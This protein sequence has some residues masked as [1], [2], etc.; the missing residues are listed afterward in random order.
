MAQPWI[1]LLTGERADRAQSLVR[2]IAETLWATEPDLPDLANGAAGVAL[3]LAYFATI[4]QSRDWRGRAAAL[5]FRAFDT[6]RRSER[7]ESFLKGAAGIA[8]AHRHVQRNF[9]VSGPD[10]SV[11]TIDGL[12]HEQLSQTPWKGV[13]E[14]AHGL[15]GYGVYA[16]ECAD[17]PAG[18]AL[19][20]RVVER[21]EATALPSRHGLTWWTAPQ[22]ITDQERKTYPSGYFNLGLAH[23]VPSVIAILGYSCRLGIA[24]QK[25]RR[26][27]EK[28]I[29]WLLAQRQPDEVG[30]CFGSLVPLLG[31]APPRRTRLGWCFG[32]LGIASA[33]Y[34]AARNTGRSDWEGEALAIA[35]RAA[36]RPFDGSGVTEA[37]VCH[38]AAGNAHLFN[39]L[40]QA[41][42]QAAFREAAQAWF[43]RT[44]TYH[45]SDG[46]SSTTT[47]ETSASRDESA[48][49]NRSGGWTD[50]PGFFG[51]LA[52]IG[53][54]LLAAVGTTDP[55]W[56][57]ILLI[58]GPPTS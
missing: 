54:T 14:L 49:G 10:E 8:W 29:A 24:D 30:S 50:H 21:L 33:L 16:A 3:F 22:N 2:S 9:G 42:G 5:L 34:A 51:G 57:R 15:V 25:A 31:K 35:E 20:A 39:R 38:G 11:S 58:S 43:D 7:P 27:L 41:T 48:N 52:G 26:L 47:E 6:A 40:Y 1:R 18:Q 19:L 53:L 13:Y 56:D 28:S 4:D 17:G 55:A 44:F 45:E 36:S 37:T 12:L 23:G 32:D 46:R